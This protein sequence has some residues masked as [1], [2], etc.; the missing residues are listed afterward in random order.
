MT[1]S[2]PFNEPLVERL[3]DAGTVD[4]AGSLYAVPE[5]DR[6]AAAHL[7]SRRGLWIHAD[8][9]ADASAG[10]SLDLIA[11]LAEDGTGPIDVHLLT[12]AALDVLDRVCRPGIARITV[13]F[14]GI[15]DIEAV[16]AR[17]RGA[18]AQPWLA[19][20]PGTQIEHCRDALTHVDGLLV[21]LIPPGTKQSADLANLTKVDTGRARRTGVDGG[22]HENNVESILAAGTRYVVVGRRLF[23]CTGPDPEGAQQ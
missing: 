10:V 13:P 7:L 3:C 23:A 1:P 15:G 4:I 6:A 21:M 11:E 20:A 12:S 2:L 19:V 8:V 5:H 14:E 9:F 17:I 16:C 22:V 18:G